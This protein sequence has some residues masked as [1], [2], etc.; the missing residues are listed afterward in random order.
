MRVGQT[1]ILLTVSKYFGSFIGFLTTIYFARTL[2]AEILGYYSLILIVANWSSLFGKVGISS[3]INKRISE[4]EERSAYYS[5]G[6]LLALGLSGILVVGIILL[7]DSIDSYVGVTAWMFIAVLAPLSI[8]YSIISASLKG[9]RRVHLVAFLTPTQTIGRS[10]IQIGLVVVGYGLTGMIFGYIAGLVL[11]A[12]LGLWFIS[13]NFEMPSKHNFQQIYSF[14]KFSWLGNLKGRSFND[15]DVLVLGALVSPQ[16]VGIYS[17]AWG[18]TNFIGIFGSSIR[19]TLFPE[20]SYADSTQQNESLSR[21]VSDSLTYSGLVAIPGVFGSL[22]VA[23]RLL[24]IYGGEFTRGVA[25]LSLLVLAMLIYD[26]QN[27]FLN[28]LNAVDRPD[29]AFR[30]NAMFIVVNLVLNVALVYAFGWI[31]AAV[32]TVIAASLGLVV[33]FGYLRTI[34]EFDV[35]ISEVGRQLTAAVAMTLVVRA[36]R[37]GIESTVSNIHNTMFVVSLVMMG[38]G[39]YFA[40]LFAISSQFRTTVRNNSPISLPS[41]FYY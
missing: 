34:I 37:L 7:R 25:V 11:A 9:E 4:T 39:V 6:I 29:I 14:A 35:P 2:G 28:G 23:D 19:N 32:A 18:I 27:Q 33:S 8:L 21:L 30:V 40:V 17:A 38:A 22:I 5:A 26:Y 36:T 41:V 10:L 1:S 20:L 3:A 12:A 31:G 16:L 13:L 15:V 24:R